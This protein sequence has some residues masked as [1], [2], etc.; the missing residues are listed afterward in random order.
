MSLTLRELLMGWGKG[1]Q[2]IRSVNLPES[3][4]VAACQE[5]ITNDVPKPPSSIDMEQIT[6]KFIDA[7]EQ[8]NFSKITLKEWRLSPFVLDFSGR[9]TSSLFLLK[10]YLDALIEHHQHHPQKRTFRTLAS[11]YARTFEMKSELTNCLGEFLSKHVALVGPIWS[12]AHKR[13]SIFNPEMALDRIPAHLKTQA[14]QN[15]FSLENFEKNESLPQMLKTS[16]LMLAAIQKSLALITNNYTEL[17][18]KRDVERV[19][20]LTSIDQ[21]K[22]VF[23][24][25]SSLV[26]VLTNALLLPFQ[27]IAPPQDMRQIIE[28]YLLQLFGDPRL[29]ETRWAGAKSESK[30][31]IFRWLT[32]QSLGLFLDIVD[33][34]VMDTDDA[35]RMWQ[36]RVI[37]W[38]AYLAKGYIDA[39]WVLFE[40]ECHHRAQQVKYRTGTSLEFG[41][42][43]SPDSRHAVLIMRIDR[44]TI[45]DWSHNGRCHIWYGSNTKAPKLYMAKG[46]KKQLQEFSDEAYTHDYYGAWR[47]KVASVIYQHTGRQV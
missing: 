16:S 7:A 35:K 24:G 13:Y 39:A 26:T 10:R 23:G 47:A 31:I 22:L 8:N 28:R 6:R 15:D 5:I 19:I 38:R 25:A 21:K 27:H 45:V 40:D 3:K 34:V 36:N 17:T 11:V 2:V 4:T 33:N 20:K 46:N 18:D 41:Q 9:L 37:F 42:L 44:L 12:L 29:N 30:D 14:D 1:T 32:E 43:F